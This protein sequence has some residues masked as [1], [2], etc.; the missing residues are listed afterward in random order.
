MQ[1][2]RGAVNEKIWS[3]RTLKTPRTSLLRH[4]F[5]GG[6]AQR[7]NSVRSWCVFIFSFSCFF[8]FSWF[9]LVSSSFQHPVLS[10]VLYNCLSSA[11]F[12]LFCSCHFSRHHF[13]TSLPF[14]FRKLVRRICCSYVINLPSVRRPACA[15]EF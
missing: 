1:S 12:T 14:L 6:E 9:F 2:E 3:R 10:F 5:S 15:E 8:S 7:K 13:L 4:S 11:L